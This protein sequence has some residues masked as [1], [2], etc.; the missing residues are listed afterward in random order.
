[1]ERQVM[2]ICQ[3]VNC[4]IIT[5]MNSC[6]NIPISEKYLELDDLFQ[7]NKIYIG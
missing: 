1:M 3:Q 5:D 4:I 2:I 6:N 7:I